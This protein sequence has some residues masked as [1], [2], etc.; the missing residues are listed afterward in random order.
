MSG[1]ARGT[2]E[3][4]KDSTWF[5]GAARSGFAASGIVQALVGVL[6]IQVAVQGGGRSAD[7]SGAL[8]SLAKAP[9]GAIVVWLAAIGGL[10]LALWL[11]LDGILERDPDAKEAW[12]AR[13]K[14]WG[15]AVVYG[16]VGVTAL[17]VALGSG[18]SSSGTTKQGSA[19]LLDLPGG[20]VLLAIVGIAVVVG[21]GALV[22]QGVA[23][24]FVKTISV[25]PGEA[26]RAVVLL[27]RVGYAARGVAI[28]V[29]GVLFV[30]AAVQADP[31]EASGLDGALRSFADLP[32]GKVVLIAIGVGWIASGVYSV[33][34]A[35]LAKLD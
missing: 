26:G 14:S 27:G 17:R 4:A 18:S 24:R 30:I 31:K 7:Q 32:F 1:Q 2:A 11:V 3:R 16:A 10:L 8:E 23:K 22:Y 34:R 6:A 9:G 29:V 21:G 25:P 5:R 12:K 15:K 19:T 35:R 20:Q 33:F 13:L 28:A